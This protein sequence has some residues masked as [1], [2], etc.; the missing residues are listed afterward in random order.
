MD[1]KEYYTGAALQEMIKLQQ[2]VEVLREPLLRKILDNPTASVPL[3]A[4]EAGYLKAI[5]EV[6]EI[7]QKERE[8]IIDYDK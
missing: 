3:N 7:F 8:D 2:K 1:Y 4:G 6:L 5:N